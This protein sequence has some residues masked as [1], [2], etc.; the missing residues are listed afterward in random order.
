[1]RN[2]AERRPFASAILALAIVLLIA[3]P[4]RAIAFPYQRCPRK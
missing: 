2:D 1:M 4:P 3:I